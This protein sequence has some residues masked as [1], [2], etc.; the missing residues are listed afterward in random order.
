MKMG[1][2]RSRVE[3]DLNDLKYWQSGEG[4]GARWQKEKQGREMVGY[5]DDGERE[6]KEG[7]T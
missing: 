7:Q 3:T 4:D 2:G 6:T 1:R 5:M